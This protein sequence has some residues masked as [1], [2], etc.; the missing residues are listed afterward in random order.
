MSHSY[1]YRKFKSDLE[2]GLIFWTFKFLVGDKLLIISTA[3]KKSSA[4]YQG[5]IFLKMKHSRTFRRRELW[6][7]FYGLITRWCLFVNK[8]IENLFLMFYLIFIRFI[9]TNPL[10]ANTFLTI[11][12]VSIFSM[13]IWVEWIL[14]ERNSLK[15]ERG[16]KSKTLFLQFHCDLYSFAKMFTVKRAKKMKFNP[17]SVK[18]TPWIMQGISK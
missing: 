2:I 11:S 18:I 8:I 5:C 17:N 1:F 3:K 4:R 13:R 10:T 7:Q 16:V 14:L 9:T 6:W 12:S 15:C